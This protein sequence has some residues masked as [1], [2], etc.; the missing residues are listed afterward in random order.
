MRPW[1]TKLVRTIGPGS[2]ASKSASATGARSFSRECTLASSTA[3]DGVSS[4]EAT[5]GTASGNGSYHT[6]A[7]VS[8]SPPRETTTAG[9][10]PSAASQANGCTMTPPTRCASRAVVAVSAV[11]HVVADPADVAVSQVVAAPAAVA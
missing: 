11:M 8:A 7:A 9:V 1:P 5:G 3:V 6:H 4:T 2:A 10:S